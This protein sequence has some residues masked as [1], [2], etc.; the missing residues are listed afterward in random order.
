MAAEY[1]LRLSDHNNIYPTEESTEQAHHALEK[2]VSI[3]LGDDAGQLNI[4]QLRTFTSLSQG[5]RLILTPIS[6]YGLRLWSVGDPIVCSIAGT[7]TEDTFYSLARGLLRKPGTQVVIQKSDKNADNIFELGIDGIEFCLQYHQ[8]P[9]AASWSRVENEIDRQEAIKNLSFRARQRMD[10][11]MTSVGLASTFKKI[12]AQQ[13][14]YHARAW[15]KNHGVYSSA[16]S[17]LSEPDFSL[18]VANQAR[19]CDEEDLGAFFR[20]FLASMPRSTSGNRVGVKVSTSIALP[21]T[22]LAIIETEM[23]KTTDELDQGE[24]VSVSKII[25]PRHKRFM[26]DFPRYLKISMSFWGSSSVKGGRF[27]RAIETS[28]STLAFRLGKHHSQLLPRAWP[29]PFVPR[30]E[31]NDSSPSYEASYLIGLH[32]PSTRD[33]KEKLQAQVEACLRDIHTHEHYDTTTSFVEIKVVGPI[34]ADTLNPS[35][36]YWGPIP[37]QLQRGSD[38]DDEIPST[39]T[40][41]PKS[42]TKVLSTQTEVETA[43]GPLRPALDIL[44]RIRYDDS[45]DSSDFVIGYLDRHA[46]MQE[47]P[48]EWWE[49]GEQTAEEFIPQSR[50][51]YFKRKSDDVLVWDREKRVDLVFGSGRSGV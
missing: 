11:Y 5:V 6:L 31:S 18:I 25:E 17:Y 38:S 28:V 15:A 8:S 51:R 24:S 44:H 46:G 23:R 37:E 9:L 47:M 30:Q 48:F 33:E 20:R 3:L 34:D 10:E 32:T 14:Y 7:P 21:S 12:F 4:A 36:K 22:S 2:L 43:V 42:K 39:S 26:S 45:L 1:A 29:V 49:G 50:I 40:I 13:C 41:V 16:F 27:A 19:E 35:E